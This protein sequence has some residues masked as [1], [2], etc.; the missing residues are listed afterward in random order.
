MSTN[1][2]H[3]SWTAGVVTGVL[4]V[5][6][7]LNRQKPTRGIRLLSKAALRVLILV[8]DGRPPLQSSTQLMPRTLLAEK[9]HE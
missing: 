1:S 7:D 2:W 4:L 5:G 8:H 9:N 6:S 3:S